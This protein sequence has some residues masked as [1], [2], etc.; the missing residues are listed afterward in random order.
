MPED[1]D[2]PLDDL[3]DKIKERAEEGGSG[4]PGS[5]SHQRFIRLLAATTAIFAV[6][7]AV[8]ALAS[9]NY[10]NEA[11]FKA[12]QAVLSQ[13]RATDTWGEYQADGLKRIAYANAAV[14][15]QQQGATGKPVQDA[16]DNATR[17]G[18]KQPPLMQRA[19]CL[20]TEASRLQKESDEQLQ[21]HH[22][23]AFAVTLFQVAIGL[24]ALGAL[25]NVQ[26]L[27]WLSM[28]AGLAGILLFA[29]GFAPIHNKDAAVESPSGTATPAAWHVSPAG[30]PVAGSL[31]TAHITTERL[32][33]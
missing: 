22:R 12:N 29:S 19:L 25:V 7:A 20:Q 11:L 24:A 26:P 27:W 3:Q 18:A 6:F 4:R 17:E 15:L 1:A 14:S 33:N 9:G 5:F 32:A 13:D 10:A 28:L 31:T 21:H 2:I 16:L 30:R 23:F 8:A